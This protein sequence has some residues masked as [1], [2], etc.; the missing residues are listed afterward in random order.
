MLSEKEQLCWKSSYFYGQ[1][2]FHFRK[3]SKCQYTSI[4][5][6][7]FCIF[8]HIIKSREKVTQISN[9]TIRQET[10]YR[11]FYVIT[12]M[13]IWNLLQNKLFP[14]TCLCVCSYMPFYRMYLLQFYFGKRKKKKKSKQK[15][16]LKEN[17][18]FFEK[19]AQQTLAKKNNK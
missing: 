17:C 3:I 13:S 14:V 19:Y 7:F 16:V 2:S 8:G 12:S 11:K 4:F 10:L 9:S 6:Y 18:S 1:I 15:S 5:Y